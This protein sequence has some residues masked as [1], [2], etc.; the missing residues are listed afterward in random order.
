MAPNSMPTWVF[1]AEV[2]G[3]VALL[4][5]VMA[6]IVWRQ[7]RGAHPPPV[8]HNPPQARS[9]SNPD[10][11]RRRFK[12]SVQPKAWERYL[13]IGLL[14]LGI[15]VFPMMMAHGVLPKHA[16]LFFAV[17]I[18][19]GIISSLAIQ[20]VFIWRK[21]VICVTTE[22]L[23]VSKRTGEVFALRNAELGQ[24]R[25]GGNRVG[26]VPVGPY[27]GRALFLT[28]GSDRFVLGDLKNPGNS[29]HVPT[30]GPQVD[31]QDLDA[32]TTESSVFDE[33]LAI[34]GSA[35]GE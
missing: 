23:T 35:R 12:V 11:A 18:G 32:W 13:T 16:V 4:M 14:L 1:A 15:G 8:A 28:S 21:L 6:Y 17:V 10:P 25:K 22:G 2:A 19:Y 20:W 31:H 3:Y 5:G 7:R 29:Q 30:E 24:W 33:L 27:V 26:P 9:V 34:V